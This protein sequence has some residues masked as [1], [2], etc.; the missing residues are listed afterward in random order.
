[1][2]G[3]LTLHRAGVDPVVLLENTSPAVGG[4]GGCST[5]GGVGWLA[6]LS[7]LALRVLRRF[8]SLF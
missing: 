1:M 3:L 8:G 5:G 2:D 7:L 4:G 6:L